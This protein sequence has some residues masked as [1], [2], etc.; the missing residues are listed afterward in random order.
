MKEGLVEERSE[1]L[2]ATL[3]AR[4]PHC[5]FGLR[6][7]QANLEELRPRSRI[8]EFTIS[9]SP[10][11]IAEKIL[12]LEPR[13]VGFGVYIWNT[14]QTER[15]ISILKRVRPG[16][17]IVLGGPEV[18][19]EAEGQSICGLADAVIQGEAEFLFR[20]FCRATLAGAPLPERKW[21]AGPLP[22]ILR[23]ALPYSLYTD[24]DIRRRILY[25]EASRG[26]PYK[27][28]YC[29][30]S[31]DKSVRN[32]DLDAFLSEMEGLIA[33]GA[34]Q[35]KFV[36]RTFNL[37]IPISARILRFF[38]DRMHLGLFIHFELVPDRLPA[39]L[40]ELIARFPAGALQFEIG[41]QT[42]N[43]EVS[44]LISR[45][46]DLGKIRENFAYLGAETGVHTHA[47]LIVG[48]PGET[49]ESFGRGFD[50]LAELAPD[51][52]QVG[53]LK[54]LKGT[55]IMRHDLEWEMVYEDHPPFQIL[56]N[57]TMDYATIQAMAR[58]SKFWDLV[59]NSGN[60]V[61]T[62]ALLREASRLRE[63]PSFFWLFH[64]LSRFLHGRH[65][66]THGI[67][68]LNLLESMWVYLTEELGIEA[69]RARETLVA[70]YAGRVSRDIPRFLRDPAMLSQRRPPRLDSLAPGSSLPERQ[71][72][73]LAAS[74]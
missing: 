20:D 33:R 34:R 6:Y 73:H 58:F 51:E 66:Q 68:L 74:P 4:Y 63:T 49:L 35:F 19:H 1:I 30:S 26:C 69:S 25:V 14:E 71:R 7:L 55:P 31:L 40:R 56:R 3:N 41:I 45:R 9:E 52:I 59:A 23:I 72:R 24:D 46:Q 36:D 17:I 39:E 16:L 37:S 21:I 27:C 65:P 32:F 28:E 44:R 13:L 61:A 15:V 64:D 29:L 10:K 42:W 43:P 60:F 5:A 67:S 54:R 38:L 50:A 18:S 22:D 48:L 57:R 11:D 8:A 47:D 70:D 2:L 62:T 12:A 53:I